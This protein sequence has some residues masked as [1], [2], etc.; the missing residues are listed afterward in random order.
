MPAAKTFE[1]NMKRIEEI[2][3]L[4]ENGDVP[5]EKSI[6]LFEEGAALIK[7]CSSMLDKA[8]QKVKLLT[9]DKTAPEISDFDDWKADNNDTI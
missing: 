1:Q 7:K 2:A 3:V 5:L 4:L 8:E 6:S 9:A